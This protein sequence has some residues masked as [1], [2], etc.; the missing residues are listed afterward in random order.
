MVG[1]DWEPGLTGL[2]QGDVCCSG[3]G[4]EGQGSWAHLAYLLERGRN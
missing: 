1:A 3:L 2:L 4:T